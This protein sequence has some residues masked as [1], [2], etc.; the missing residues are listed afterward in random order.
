MIINALYLH[1]GTL[2]TL[3]DNNKKSN[4]MQESKEY[5]IP[6]DNMVAFVKLLEKHDLNSGI[7][8]A[9][10]DDTIC[11]TVWYFP[12]WPSHHEGLKEIDLLAD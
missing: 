6:Q 11:I 9:E 10:G 12:D 4:K 3:F 1:K 2:P 7:N 8:Y 5:F